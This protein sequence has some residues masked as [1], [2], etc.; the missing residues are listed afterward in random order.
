MKSQGNKGFGRV[1]FKESEGFWKS[2]GGED[3]KRWESASWN[4]GVVA[5][6]AERD[7]YRDV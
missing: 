4:H 1:Y 2:F 5:S 6:N 7:R 3:D